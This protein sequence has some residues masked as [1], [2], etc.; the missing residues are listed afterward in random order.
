MRTQVPVWSLQVH[1]V[2]GRIVGL[3]PYILVNAKDL[4]PSEEALGRVIGSYCEGDF[5]Y[6][7]NGELICNTGVVV[8]LIVP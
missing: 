5:K 3:Y 4:P 1:G 7:A 8:G 2:L 6:M